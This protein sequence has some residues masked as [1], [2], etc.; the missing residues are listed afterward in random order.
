MAPATTQVGGKWPPPIAM[1]G[2]PPGLLRPDDLCCIRI[3]HLPRFFDMD[4]T[5]FTTDSPMPFRIRRMTGAAPILQ[6]PWSFSPR[7][8]FLVH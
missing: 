4:V 2:S 3:R 1:T 5:S 8:Y 6:W 7:G